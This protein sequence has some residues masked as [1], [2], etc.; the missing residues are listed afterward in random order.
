MRAHQWEKARTQGLE[1]KVLDIRT[2][3]ASDQSLRTKQL[4]KF[5]GRQGHSRHRA[6]LTLTPPGTGGKG[7][8][9]ADS[10]GHM[11]GGGSATGR[12]LAA[13]TLL[14]EGRQPKRPKNRE[15]S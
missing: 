8:A 12:G 14:W 10:E 5:W 6:T 13:R 3:D 4:R 1:K 2:G 15:V 11:R 9:G 7:S